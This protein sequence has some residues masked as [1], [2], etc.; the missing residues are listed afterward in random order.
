MKVIIPMAGMGK[1]MRPH[2]L[3]IPKP[4]I[5]VAGKPIVQHLVE[6]LAEVCPEPIT[7]VNFVIGRFG[8]D[9]EKLLLNVAQSIGAK[10]VISYQ[11]EA[12]GTAHA[13]LCGKD[14]LS[15]KVIVAFADTLFKADFKL[16]TQAEGIIW[17]SRVKNPEAFGVVQTNDNGVVEAFV[18]KPETFISDRA[19]IGIYYFQ[20]GDRLQKELQRLIDNDIRIK[21]G[22]FGL[23]DA[24]ENMKKSGVQFRI[25][26]VSEWLDCG[27][28]DATVYT[29]QRV[30][31]N[32]YPEG[33]VHPSA[34]FENCQVIPPCLIGAG[35]KL[36]NTVIGPWVSIGDN[37]QISNA[38]IS[39][40]II[41]GN[42]KILNA[43]LQNSMVGNFVTINKKSQELS[44]GDYNQIDA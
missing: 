11:D 13:I 4:L 17:T 24:L 33:H 3:T 35:A 28:K 16:D 7:E 15:E 19:I 34:Q 23:T 27:N 6:D 26:T 18:E 30:L 32:K 22:E 14:S 29:N 39:N 20:D 31:E 41:Q 44:I 9:T 40:S 12:L 25:D 38:V 2:S 1:R 5:P 42:S 36:S 37:T 8:A 10:G 21:G 43:V